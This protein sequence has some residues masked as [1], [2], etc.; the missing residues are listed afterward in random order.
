MSA[1][2]LIATMLG[3]YGLTNFGADALTSCGVI[4]N[5]STISSNTPKSNSE[6]KSTTATSN[7]N[8]GTTSSNSTTTYKDGTYTGSGTGFKGRT[9]K[10]SVTVADGKVTKI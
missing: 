2:L 7:Q 8:Q 9:T 4:S 3:V 1:Q 10:V 6:T 5:N